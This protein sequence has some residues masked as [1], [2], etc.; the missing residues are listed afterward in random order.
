MA[1]PNTEG[2][3]NGVVGKVLAGAAIV[4]AGVVAAKLINDNKDGISEGLADAKEKGTQVVDQIKGDTVDTVSR[5]F[6]DLKKKID[7]SE[8]AK[9]LSGRLSYI[10]NG[11]KKIK[12]SNEDDVAGLIKRFKEQIQNLQ[13]DFEDKE[14][15]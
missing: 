4:G 9:D 2:G 14:Q 10:A 3:N 7:E 8:Q 1:N 13:K 15:K 12:E 11:L 6:E 5:A